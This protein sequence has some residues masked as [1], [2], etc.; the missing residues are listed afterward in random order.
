MLFQELIIKNIKREWIQYH[1][2]RLANL[3]CEIM[4]Q[5]HARL[6]GLPG[7][8]NEKGNHYFHLCPIFQSQ[9]TQARPAM[10]SYSL[11]PVFL[12][13]STPDALP[14]VLK[15]AFP[16]WLRFNLQWSS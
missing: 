8:A 7:N 1:T 10:A 4:G 15:E 9:V 12:V 3:G 16:G 11:S 14:L 2:N 13:G 5:F 6:L